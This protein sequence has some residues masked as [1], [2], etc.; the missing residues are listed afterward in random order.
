[1]KTGKTLLLVGGTSDIG[2]AT[3]LRFAAAGWQIMLAA[4]NA[5][6]AQRNADD[7]AARTGAAV[8]VH[9]LDK[10][11]RAGLNEQVVLVRVLYEDGTVWQ[12]P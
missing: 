9:A 1:M 11:E 3:A 8:S 7:V 10:R 12:R 4:R 2:R 5:D 6:A